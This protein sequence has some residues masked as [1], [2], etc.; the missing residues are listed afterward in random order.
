MASSLGWLSP[1]QKGFLPGV[2][3]I[4]EHTQL[5][6]TVVEEA[7]FKRRNMSVAWLD[8]CNAFGSIPHLV[9]IELFNSLPI[10]DD[11]KRLLI[12]LL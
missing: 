6:Q 10:P 12:G 1:E 7:T 2:R 11:L 8:L 9:L 4:Q 5:L 3:G